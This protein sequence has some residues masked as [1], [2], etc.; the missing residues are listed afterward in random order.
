M[1][2]DQKSGEISLRDFFIR[3]Y[4]QFDQVHAFDTYVFCLSL[5]DA[6]NTNGLLS[7]WRGYGR[8]GNGAAL[9]FNTDF[10]TGENPNS[11]LILTRVIYDTENGR[12]EWLKNRMSLWCQILKAHNIPDEKLYIAASHLFETIKF[13][14][15]KSKHD[16]FSEEQEWRMIYIPERDTNEEF[17]ALRQFHYVVGPRGM[18]PKLIL[19]IC[20]IWFW[21]RLEIH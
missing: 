7:M 21:R 1:P 3:Y 6:K 5:H 10:I 14:A 15:L 2:V 17:K 9:V 19:K 12:V 11:P 13:Y 4:A 16:G 8:R 18:E 20:P